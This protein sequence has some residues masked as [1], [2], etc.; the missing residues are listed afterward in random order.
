MDICGYILESSEPYRSL[1]SSLKRLLGAWVFVAHFFSL[2]FK[3]CEPRCV[4]LVG[5]RDSGFCGLGFHG[6]PGPSNVVPF[7]VCYGFGLGLLLGLPKRYYIAGFR[8]CLLF[9]LA[10]LGSFWSAGSGARLP[11]LQAPGLVGFWISGL[12][13]RIMG[14]K[15]L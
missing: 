14:V 10:I 2:G 7:G 12:G 13:P 5:C 9:R 4:V 6:L 15:G 1:S 3:A 11:R 8:Y